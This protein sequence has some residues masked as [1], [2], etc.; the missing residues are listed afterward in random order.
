MQQKVSIDDITVAQI[1]ALDIAGLGSIGQ[2]TPPKSPYE[3]LIDKKITIVTS[4]GVYFGRLWEVHP[5]ELLIHG[6][7][8]DGAWTEAPPW[9]KGFIIIGRNSICS[10]RASD[11]DQEGS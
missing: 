6:A 3:Q 2:G 7:A 9:R 4:R 1:R 5:Q 8:C 10:V 11:L